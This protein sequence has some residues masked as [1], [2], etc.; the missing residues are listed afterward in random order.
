MLAM[1]GLVNAHTHLELT[2]LIGAFSDLDLLEMMSSMTAI[3]GRL[4]EGEFD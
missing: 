2:P 3:Y 1:P 4:G